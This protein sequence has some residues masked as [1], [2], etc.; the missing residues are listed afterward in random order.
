MGFDVNF[1]VVF[2]VQLKRKEF[3][4]LY[5]RL[6]AL[7]KKE[8]EE[9]AKEKKTSNEEKKETEKKKKKNKSEKIEIESDN[10]AEQR[11]NEYL[12]S[13][14][15]YEADFSC[16]ML[17]IGTPFILKCFSYDADDRYMVV[18]KQFEINDGGDGT[19]DP[20]TSEQVE[21]FEK[22]LKEN[23]CPEKCVQYMI[24]CGG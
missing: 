21:A 20:P 13:W 2:G 24:G 12:H 16:G 19:I 9:N 4:S 18:L 14:E 23:N 10:I 6:S 11:A 5:D 7:F 17:I 15:F 3:K 8:M 22:W 1:V